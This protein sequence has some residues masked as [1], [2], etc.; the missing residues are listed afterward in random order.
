MKKGLAIVLIGCL[1][2][3]GSRWNKV[4][5]KSVIDLESAVNMLV[6]NYFDRY[7]V[8]EYKYSVIND[9]TDL[10]LVKIFARQKYDDIN[11]IPYVKGINSG[12]DIIKKEYQSKPQCLK[13]IEQAYNEALG[14]IKR[15]AFSD[16][17]FALYVKNDDGRWYVDNVD[18]FVPL[19][20]F[21]ALSEEEL[22]TRGFDYIQSVI[23]G[24]EK[25]ASLRSQL[26]YNYSL[27]NAIIYSES[28]SSNPTTCCVHGSTC[29]ML[30]D[31]SKYN[32]AYQH[33]VYGSNHKDCANFVSQ[34]L[35]AGGIPTDNTWYATSLAWINVSAL[36]Q[37]MTNNGYWTNISPSSIFVGDFISF[38]SS[39]HVALIAAFDGTHYRV[40][41]HTNDR[42]DYA[43]NMGSSNHYYRVY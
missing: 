4:D 16:Q 26:S 23:K 20:E 10:W 21:K 12:L 19:E 13:Q 14:W 27:L 39:S 1:I 38:S 25:K 36:T 8:T 34:I 24:I 41:A 33:Y 17:E 28:Y 30:V 3:C 22:Y 18:S 31:T 5:A 43:M 37:Y 9:E 35:C 32:S 11:D 15:S 6:D 40:T 42:K 7:K 29:G 2:L